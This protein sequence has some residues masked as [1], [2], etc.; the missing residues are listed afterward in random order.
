MVNPATRNDPDTGLTS[1]QS[2]SYN[3]VTRSW[4]DV[5]AEILLLLLLLLLL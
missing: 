3:D 1:A 5:E 2:S 4:C